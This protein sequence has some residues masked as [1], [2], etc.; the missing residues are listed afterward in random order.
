MSSALGE[1]STDLIGLARPLTAEPR[2]CADLIAGKTSAAKPNHVNE[3]V[4]TAA[5]Y[6]QIGHIIDR[7]ARIPDLSDDD[8]ARRVEQAIAEA[9]PE[10]MLYRAKLSV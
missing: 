2:L 10:A 4:Q 6:L 9:G 3:K 5:S 1:H 8:T 7:G